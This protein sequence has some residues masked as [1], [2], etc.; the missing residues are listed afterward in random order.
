MPPI[1]APRI[2][3][4]THD[5]F[6]L[7][8]I[9]RCTHF[10]QALSERSPESS[11][12]LVTGSPAFNALGELP[13]NADCVKIPTVVKTGTRDHAPAHLPLPLSEITALRA[14]IVRESVLAFD[15]DV[16]LVDNFPL[17]SKDELLPT[18]QALR[19]RRTRTLLGLRDVLGAPDVVRKDW[20]RQGIYRV[21]ER[22]YD[23][24]LVYGSAE[25]QD[26]AEAYRL[27]ASVA[28]KLRYC[29]YVTGEAVEPASSESVR[30]TLGVASPF[31]LATGGGGGD[32]YPLLS[33]FVDALE[34]LPPTPAV[35][36]TGPL[37][38]RAHRAELRDRSRAVADLTVVESLPD[39]RRYMAAA[40]AVVSMCGYNT[41]TEIVS[42]RCP[43]VVVPRTWRYG[44]PLKRRKAGT[45]FEQLIRARALAE[46]GFIRLVE[47]EDLVPERLAAGIRAAIEDPNE[48]SWEVDLE[49][50]ANVS[51]LLLQMA[52]GGEDLHAAI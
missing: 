9:R 10:M 38:S 25:L 1:D 45:E 12:L 27:P 19:G 48:P 21:L 23:A 18:L 17:G 29:G 49:G 7:G 41:A 36:V 47:P 35:V 13:H 52:S 50:R 42:T 2:A 32:A 33:T 51:R 3:I 34:L 28:A 46:K 37:M 24:V 11:L 26:V 40:S 5:T 44:E 4:F 39:L 14:H 15:P 30:T 31:V 6:G 16:L 43:A 8:H 22:Y 20:S